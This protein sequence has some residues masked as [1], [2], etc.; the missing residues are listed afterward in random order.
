MLIFYGLASLMFEPHAAIVNQQDVN[1]A[2]SHHEV[3][4]GLISAPSSVLR[5][6]RFCYVC[7]C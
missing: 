5:Y 1:A 6:L 7:G 3:S 2:I 4:V